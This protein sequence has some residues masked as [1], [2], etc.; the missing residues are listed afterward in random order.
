[1]RQEDGAD[2]RRLN[3]GYADIEAGRILRGVITF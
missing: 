3:E 1:V 2:P